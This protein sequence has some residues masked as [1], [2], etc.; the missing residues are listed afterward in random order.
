MCLNQTL[1]KAV[2]AVLNPTAVPTLATTGA[3]ISA[4]PAIGNKPITAGT[5]AIIRMGLLINPKSSS[6]NFLIILVKLYNST[7]KEIEREAKTNDSVLSLVKACESTVGSREGF[8]K[9]TMSR[10][11]TISAAPMLTL[12]LTR[13]SRVTKDATTVINS[14][15]IRP[16]PIH[17]NTSN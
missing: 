13:V 3:D 12:N 1:R 8:I 14:H 17:I 6:L 5:T 4:P 7:S 10:P 15:I 2:K 9:I 16:Q 11:S